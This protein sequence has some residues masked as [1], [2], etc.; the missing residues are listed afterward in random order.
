MGS[1]VQGPSSKMSDCTDDLYGPQKP[2]EEFQGTAMCPKSHVWPVMWH[3]E[4]EPDFW[5]RRVVNPPNCPI[6][7]DRWDEIH[8]RGL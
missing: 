5:L 3:M 1:S 6:C 2:P 7:G 8:K 4:Q